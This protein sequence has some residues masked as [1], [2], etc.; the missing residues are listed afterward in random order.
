MF[1]VI[2]LSLIMAG[3]LAL[4]AWLMNRLAA[5]KPW[6]LLAVA[7]FCWVFIEWLRGWLFS[8]F[9]WMSL[10]Y[11]QID[12]ALSGWAPVLGVYGVSLMVVVSTTALL[13]AFLERDRQRWIALRIVAL[14]WVAGAALTSVQWT[15]PSGDVINTTIIQAGI[16][17]ERK[18]L[19]EE[20]QPT[21]DFYRDSTL[22]ATN[23][24]LVVWPEVA[25]PSVTDLEERYIQSLEAIS[26]ASADDCV[27][28]SR[29]RTNR[30]R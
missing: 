27:W 16:P 9:P 13:V 28:H 23:S 12:T 25:I 10:G 7:P 22:S 11:G 20:R 17:Q 30:H 15:E 8:G 3:Y 19:P 18:W 29:A 5:A 26:R 1:L 21:R 6:R 4:T 2:V 24:E 14:P